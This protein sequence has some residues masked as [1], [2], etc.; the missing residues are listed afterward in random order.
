MASSLVTLLRIQV[1]TTAAL[2]QN[3]TPLGPE[4]PDAKAVLESYDGCAVIEAPSFDVLATAFADEYYRTVIE[5][6]ER[7]FIDKKAGILRARGESKKII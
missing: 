4:S 6:D 5:P 2:N 3:T 1:H 7:K